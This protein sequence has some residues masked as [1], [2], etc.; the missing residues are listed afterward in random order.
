MKFIV[1]VISTLTLAATNVLAASPPTLNMG[2]RGTC[3]Q[4][5]SLYKS[6]PDEDGR[7]NPLYR[8]HMNNLHIESSATDTR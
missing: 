4:C 6:D 8:F 5:K 7:D 3:Q 2:G 1:P